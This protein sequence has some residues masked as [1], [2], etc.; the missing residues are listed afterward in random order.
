M[1]AEIEGQVKQK[2]AQWFSG[3]L[4][5]KKDLPESENLACQTMIVSTWG[6][7]GERGSEFAEPNT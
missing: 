6:S 7:P 1:L 5:M 2:T 3:R 4:R